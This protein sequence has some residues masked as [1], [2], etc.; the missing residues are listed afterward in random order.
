MAAVSRGVRWLP[1]AAVVLAVAVFVIVHATAGANRVRGAL[2]AVFE[3][4]TQTCHRPA[5]VATGAPA[6]EFVG[7]VN[8]RVD[9]FGTGP[10]AAGNVYTVSAP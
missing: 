6:S 5:R 9:T 2:A 8:V 4:P 10:K 7:A 3:D 1:A